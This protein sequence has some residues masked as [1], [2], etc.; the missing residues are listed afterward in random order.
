MFG[1][2]READYAHH[3]TTCPPPPRIFRPVYGP[4]FTKSTKLTKSL[5]SGFLYF[6]KFSK[7]KGGDQFWILE[8]CLPYM[9]VSS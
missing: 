7:K 2:S 4:G 8:L 9:M 1:K 3:I 6:N 5:G